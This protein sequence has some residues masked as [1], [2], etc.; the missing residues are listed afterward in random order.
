MVGLVPYFKN[1]VFSI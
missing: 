1:C